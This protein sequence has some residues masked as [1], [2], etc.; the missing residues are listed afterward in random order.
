MLLFNKYLMKEVLFMKQKKEPINLKF[1]IVILLFILLIIAVAGVFL[2]HINK[3]IIKYEDDTNTNTTNNNILDKTDVPINTNSNSISNTTTSKQD[4]AVPKV[5]TLDI[6]SD[7]VQKLYNYILKKS[8]YEEN[9][10]YLYKKVTN[11][12]IDNKLKLMTVFTNLEY[13]DIYET[14]TKN[15]NG[16][17]ITHTLYKSETVEKKAREIFGPSV[18][19]V[20]ESCPIHFSEAIDYKNGIYDC[21]SYQG[22]GITPWESSSF[23]LKKAEQKE[24]EIYIY[25]TYTHVHEDLENME[26]TTTNKGF[27]KHTFIKN[28]DGSYYWYC[29]EPIDEF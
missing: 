22:G 6:S 15:E 19:I 8:D 16:M 10:V 2:Y 27:Y 25:D 23:E 9:L 24:N 3:S 7:L 21:Y 14:T 4:V 1:T 11:E 26:K 28:S 13:S 5:E 17:S 18:S 20:H 29:T 12:T